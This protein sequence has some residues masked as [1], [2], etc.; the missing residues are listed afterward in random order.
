MTT[1][2]LATPCGACTHTLNWHTG[3]D[4][5]TVRACPC[6][7]FTTADYALLLPLQQLIDRTIRQAPLR[8]GNPHD[9]DR[10]TADL[11]LRVCAW[12]GRNVLP[13]TTPE[14]TP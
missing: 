13:A 6:R 14:A 7:R 10:L 2:T 9:L 11:T 3:S 8:P 5:C 12:V 1:P 4:A